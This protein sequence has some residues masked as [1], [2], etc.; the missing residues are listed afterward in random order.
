MLLIEGG[1]LVEDAGAR[2][3]DVL[4]DGERIAAVGPDLDA[5]GAEVVDAGGALVIPG[6][7]VSE[8]RLM[9]RTSP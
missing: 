6:G 9:P 7:M 2:P 4:I 8:T 5:P 1:T 3:G